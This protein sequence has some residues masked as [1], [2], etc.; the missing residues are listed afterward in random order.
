MSEY[1]V[2]KGLLTKDQSS[3]YES[4]ADMINRNDKLLD[5]LMFLENM[6]QHHEE[7]Y[8]NERAFKE[9]PYF[10]VFSNVFVI[11]M[12]LHEKQQSFVL[13]TPVLRKLL[14]IKQVFKDA[15]EGLAFIDGCCA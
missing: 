2:L 1:D 7:A 10:I 6:L 5:R 15:E 13:P 11:A 8:T 9:T 12:A 14:D 3:D 4:F